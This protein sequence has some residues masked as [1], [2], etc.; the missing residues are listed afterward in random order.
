MD[1]TGISTTKAQEILDASIQTGTVDEAG[2]LVLTNGA[3]TEFNA[4]VVIEPFR[5][6]PVGSVFV[7]IS[8]DNP[9]VAL[10]GGTWERFAKGRTLV[11]LDEAQTEF[12]TV[13]ETGGEKTHLLTPAE[14]PR[15]SHGYNEPK[16]NGNFGNFTG[17]GNSVIEY[18]AFGNTFENP[19][20][21]PDDP[22]DQPHN[23]LQ[24]YINVYMWLRT[25]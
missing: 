17:G 11:S 3:G 24:P 7:S 5:S 2:N 21:A 25:A 16:S 19:T 22:N 20:D 4:G 10:G 23:N 6:W 15:H 12:D 14:L 13:L 1:V 8:P 9:A 18:T